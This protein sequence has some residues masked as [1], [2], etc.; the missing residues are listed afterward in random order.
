MQKKREMM[1]EAEILEVPEVDLSPLPDERG[2]DLTSGRQS[3]RLVF[4]GSV[5]DGEQKASK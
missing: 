5:D 2:S 4:G 3:K 1:E